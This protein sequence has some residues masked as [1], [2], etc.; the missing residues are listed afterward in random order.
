MTHLFRIL[1][2][3]LIGGGIV[4]VIWMNLDSSSGKNTPFP[5]VDTAD[6]PESVI[7]DMTPPSP[8]D[9]KSVEE[10]PIEDTLLPEEVETRD[11]K[12]APLVST[13]ENSDSVAEKTEPVDLS[14][15]QF[16]TE[17]STDIAPSSEDANLAQISLTYKR[18]LTEKLLQA[19]LILIRIDTAEG[20]Y[21]ILPSED[22]V[23]A[24]THLNLR[25]LESNSKG[26]QIRIIDRRFTD[27]VNI[28]RIAR[29]LARQLRQAENINVSIFATP[30]LEAQMVAQNRY[31]TGLLS[32]QET[33]LEGVIIIGCFENSPS[34]KFRA[35]SIIRNTETIDISEN[36]V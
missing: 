29:Q 18:G 15:S 22:N 28:S 30:K 36:C 8:L 33:G 4:F 14:I 25:P 32:D 26:S 2:S 24:F 5:P 17:V 11:L 23:S 6:I 35:S 34:S 31:A 7:L 9:D 10:N 20:S 19:G 12:I 3:C 27:E 21:E 16:E 1:S 13:E